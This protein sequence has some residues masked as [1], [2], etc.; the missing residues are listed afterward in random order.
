MAR[1]R[2]RLDIEGKGAFVGWGH[3]PTT[4]LLGMVVTGV[5]VVVIMRGGCRRRFGLGLREHL[6]ELA[7][8]AF[9][10]NLDPAVFRGV[11]RNTVREVHSTRLLIGRQ[12]NGLQRKMRRA[13]ALVRGGSAMARQAHKS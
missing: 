2:W 3:H 7:I 11:W 13:A 5:I 4:R 10:V 9:H 6:L 12:L 1:A 8:A